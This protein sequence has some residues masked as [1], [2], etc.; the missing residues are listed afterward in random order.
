ML[1]IHIP[2]PQLNLR[3]L[4]LR[5]LLLVARCL[6][7]IETKTIRVKV[8]LVTRV[9]QDLCDLPGVLKLPQVNVRPALLDGVTNKF[10]GAGLT[11]GADDG[12]LLLLA[13][14][15]DDEGGALCL[16]LCDLLGF[17]GGG[18]FG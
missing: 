6:H 13:G 4:R 10:S 7:D 16:L 18:K 2:K 15:V 3:L 11:L 8:D 9:L 1:I 14:F 17:D 12:G 5:P